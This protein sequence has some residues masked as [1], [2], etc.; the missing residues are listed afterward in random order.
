MT[1]IP[2]AA[3]QTAKTFHTLHTADEVLCL[4]NAWDVA[5]ARLVEAAGASAIA[6]TSAG[7]AWSLG[8]ADGDRLD[9]AVAIDRIR[10]IAAVTDLPVTADVESGYSTDADGVGETV[11][12]VIAAGAVGVNIE[13]ATHDNGGPLR[14]LADQS[15]RI[16]AAREAADALGV[17]LYVNARS[18]TY[19]AAVGPESGRLAETLDR[20]AGFVAA[21]ADGVFVPGVKD[22]EIIRALAEGIDAP[23][24]IL[25]GPGSPSVSELRD[26]GVARVSLGSTIVRAAYALVRRGASELFDAGTY[27]SLADELPYGEVNALL[28]R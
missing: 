20:A 28:S 18:D 1:A 2:P 27:S 10:E 8:T 23:L 9:R 5:T 26:L 22:P 17:P 14:D 3:A 13:D 11:R 16:A 15:A 24:N 25:V 21:G 4:A 19:L 6:T 7:V 12:E